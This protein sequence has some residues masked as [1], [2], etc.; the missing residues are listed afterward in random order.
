MKHTSTYR[1]T[2]VTLRP[3]VL[4]TY[5]TLSPSH[6]HLERLVR[7]VDVS[8]LALQVHV[9]YC[10]LPHPTN[11]YS[12]PYSFYRTHSLSQTNCIIQFVTNYFLHSSF[13][14]S[15]R[16]L[17]GRL[18]ILQRTTAVHS[19]FHT[20]SIYRIPSYRTSTVIQP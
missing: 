19:S 16:V 20:V 14:T 15:R 17:S 11:P 4:S 5:R 8:H 3:T 9:G 10:S 13:S 1:S 12:V 7:A 6:L 2:A 18:A